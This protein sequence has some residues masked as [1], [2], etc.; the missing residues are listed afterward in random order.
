MNK[1]A[2]GTRW[3][4][5]LPPHPSCLSRRSLLPGS[6][7]LWPPARPFLCSP[8]KCPVPRLC[9]RACSWLPACPDPPLV[10][11]ALVP[12]DAVAQATVPLAQTPG[13]CLPSRVVSL[14]C[15]PSP[16]ATPHWAKVIFFLKR[17]C[18]ANFS[19][20]RSRLLTPERKAPNSLVWPLTWTP[21]CVPRLRQA[22]GS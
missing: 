8:L 3:V 22:T 12:H 9:L 18:Y 15:L 2:Q 21:P 14:C 1:G 7:C 11:S 13:Q 6:R 19:K 17:K 16:V 10:P 4:F 5:R 20:T